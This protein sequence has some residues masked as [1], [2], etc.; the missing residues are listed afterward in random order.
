MD[1]QHIKVNF[2][3]HEDA[4]VASE[5]LW[6]KRVGD[7]VYSIDNTPMYFTG[8]AV[9]DCVTVNMEG[10]LL[11]AADTETF[12]GHANIWIQSLSSEKSAARAHLE[13]M[14]K[15]LGDRGFYCEYEDVIPRLAV[16]LEESKEAKCLVGELAS[17]QIANEIEFK[18]TNKV[19]WL[20]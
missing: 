18:V 20:E 15:S 5:G 3:L 17:L 13:G 10:D 14:A 11:W 1:G 2:H 4:E 16:D 6:A 19:T 9:G 8:L 7:G 12:G